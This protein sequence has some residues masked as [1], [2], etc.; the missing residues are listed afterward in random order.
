[1]DEINFKIATFNIRSIGDYVKINLFHDLVIKYNL[2]VVCLQETHL[3][4]TNDAVE[5][6]KIFKEF[7]FF[8]AKTINKT[9]GVAILIR[10]DLLIS[11]PEFINI[12]DERFIELTFKI[13]NKK[14][15]IINVYSPNDYN[16]QINFVEHLYERIK[17]NSAKI[18]VGDFNC[19]ISE[20]ND[21][22]A[23]RKHEREWK[24]FYSSYMFQ[25]AKY[26]GTLKNIYTWTNGENKTRIDRIYISDVK[27]D[28][29]ECK[30]LNFLDIGLS[31]HKLVIAEIKIKG[32]KKERIM[33]DRMWKLN[34]SI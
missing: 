21:K 16:E 9:K 14:I 25:E 6:Q 27:N 20:N 24:E 12:F 31:D 5:F 1:M 10:E 3:N 28:L 4:N 32:T 8:Y 29:L 11:E 15:T 13:Q 7:K 2:S 34:D 17:F 33:H 18:F 30:Y 19:K 26:I 23:N 22:K